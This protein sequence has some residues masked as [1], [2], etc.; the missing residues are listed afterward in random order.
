V[1]N[2]G[3]WFLLLSKRLYK[4]ASFVMLLILI[5]LCVAAFS[6]T[7]K[8]DSGFVRVVLA[9]ENAGTTNHPVIEKLLQER[10]AIVFSCA[11]TP[12][13]AEDAV[14]AGTVDEAWIFPDDIF[15]ETQAFYDGT[16]DCLVQVIT[17]ED[18][19]VLRLSREKI[20]ASV[21]EYCA[22]VYY[23]EYIRTHI[24]QLAEKSDGALLAYFDQIEI[25]ED[26]FAYRNPAEQAGVS[27]NTT[28]LTSPI[29]GL[30]AILVLLGGMAATMFYMQDSSAGT[31]SLVKERRRGLVALGSVMTAVVHI[32][33]VALLS[34]CISSLAGGLW[35]EIAMLF[36]Y[37]LCCSAFCLLLK[38]LLP[39]IRSYCAV[40]PLLTVVMLGICPVFMDF[41]KMS[42]LQHIFPPTYYIN[43]IYNAKYLWYMAVYSVVCLGLTW[44]LQ[45][46]KTF[47][48]YRK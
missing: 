26:F 16:Q 10:G 22:K 29:R 33:L 15:G 34:L 23:L 45:K 18:D 19:M 24:P 14:R 42:V 5:P 28:Y 25:S 4:K 47:V 7:A 27:Q 12:E 30:L 8:Q 38:E 20:P 48:L 11:A 31:F 39:G 3:K 9:Q 17:R 36:L 2:I 37:A 21:Y 1:K 35:I 13:E 44:L 41:R 6:L 32:S 46:I 43:G 40:L